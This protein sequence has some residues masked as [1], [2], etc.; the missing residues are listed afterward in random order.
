[1]NEDWA[2]YLCDL[3]GTT[4]SILVD[5]GAHES[6]PDPERPTVLMVRV[7]LRWPGPEGLSTPQE[8]P[9][10]DDLEDAFIPGVVDGLG[11]R[12]VGRIT[13]GGFRDFFFYAAS[14]DGLEAVVGAG[15]ARFRDY[16]WSVSSRLE[17]DWSSYFDLLYPAPLELEWIQNGRVVE[18]LQQ[19]GDSPGVPRMVD[20]FLH[21]PSAEARRLFV[22]SLP[23]E[24]GVAGEGL[25][26][27][28]EATH[29]FSLHL[30]RHHSV[31]LEVI[32]AVV[33]EL[34]ELADGV[35]GRYDGWGSPVVTA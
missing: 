17:P 1:M 33:A 22:G 25:D 11:A 29:P 9:T 28:T 30:T 5:L 18:R 31:N 27:E 24:Y 3:G 23:A 8:A 6:S 2:F 13:A 15:V 19:S 21:F 26:R 32:D 16:T 20:H 34:Y 4:G 10:L 35:E 12:F 14:G 7:K